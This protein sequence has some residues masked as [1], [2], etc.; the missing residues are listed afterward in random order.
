MPKGAI[1]RGRGRHMSTASARKELNVFELPTPAFK[2]RVILVDQTCWDDPED[3]PADR[4]RGRRVHS[5]RSII[6]Q[7]LDGGDGWSIRRTP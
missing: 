6:E 1:G 7:R 2:G 4:R 3:D 5:N